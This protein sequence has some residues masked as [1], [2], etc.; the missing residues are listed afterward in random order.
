V[1]RLRKAR[2]RAWLKAESPHYPDIEL[3]EGTDCVVLT[4]VTSSIHRFR[5]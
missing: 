3:G 1:K 5:N 4:V 2:G